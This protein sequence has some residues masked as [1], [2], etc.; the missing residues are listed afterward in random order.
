MTT[1]SDGV[2]SK[3]THLE[4]SPSGTIKYTYEL[5]AIASKKSHNQ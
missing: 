3:K 4:N 5:S 2:E 1:L